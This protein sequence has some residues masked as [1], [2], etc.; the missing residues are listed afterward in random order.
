MVSS[1]W[2]GSVVVPLTSTVPS[3]PVRSI[4]AFLR[5]CHA[6]SAADFGTLPSD[7]LRGAG[8][9]ADTAAA[10]ELWRHDTPESWLF[11][12]GHRTKAL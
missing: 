4:T 1:V 5:S 11:L 2:G 10:R 3:A 8:S 9:S 7:M 6:V 12:G